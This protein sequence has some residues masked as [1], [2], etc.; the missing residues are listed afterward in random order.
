M[1]IISK[2]HYYIILALIVASNITLIS[3][4]FSR[5]Y[6]ISN[7]NSDNSIYALMA[8]DLIVDGKLN[9]FFYGQ[10]Y[11]GPLTSVMIAVSQLIINIIGIRHKVP[12]F[13]TDY[14]IDPLSLT[15]ASS[16]LQIMGS[17]F[18][19]EAIRIKFGYKSALIIL[20]SCL[21]G[22]SSVYAH[23]YLPNG[24]EMQLFCIG[25]LMFVFAKN[26]HQILLGIALGFGWWMNQSIV[27]IALPLLIFIMKDDSKL[28]N[29]KSELFRKETLVKNK[30]ILI[31]ML[32]IIILGVI[33]NEVGYYEIKSIVNFKSRSGTKAIILPILI[34]IL[35]VFFK[36]FVKKNEIVQYLIKL[37][38]KFKFFIIGCILSYFPVFIGVQLKWYE[39]SYTPKFELVKF[40]SIPNYIIKLIIDYY[41][42]LFGFSF[43]TFLGS[44]FFII[45]LYILTQN[46]ISLWR[47][48]IENIDWKDL[49]TIGIVVNILYVLL[50]FRSQTEYAVRYSFFLIYFSP[51]I[52]YLSEKRWIKK[53]SIGLLAI[54][55]I[56]VANHISDIRIKKQV[57]RE[58]KNLKESGY[59]LCYAN[60]WDAY[61]LEYL[62]DGNV[63]FI[64]HE[65][66]DRTKKINEA[67]KRINREKCLYN[68]KDKS[69]S[70]F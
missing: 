12:Y 47:K 45:L 38:N 1:F 31:V 8:K 35:Y 60:F 13:N 66:Q 5:E 22:T 17:L 67:R 29:L 24:P 33:S 51:L 70:K 10:N 63:Q 2:R 43:L 15:I 40:S 48:K 53:V 56:S 4:T 16:F 58:L 52:L 30:S 28:E 32:L 42:N 55:C 65:S 6:I 62:T 7:L 25:L 3:L 23:N 20:V 46:T 11:M 68:K 54:Y 19:C 49:I 59:K 27:F 36:S 26:Y 9:I 61:R 14:I 18:I 64:V 21:F 57:F 39:K 41:P 34:Y 44:M 50:S 69:I 37:V